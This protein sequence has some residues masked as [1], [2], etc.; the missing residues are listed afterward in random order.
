M[1][2]GTFNIIE[3]KVYERAEG[4]LTVN[5]VLAFL[6]NLNLHIA[7]LVHDNLRET[8]KAGH[9]DRRIQYGEVGELLE[10]DERWDRMVVHISVAG[11]RNPGERALQWDAQVYAM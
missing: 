7:I 4:R 6:R 2:G 9:A 8:P 10:Q 5:V 11:D 3:A 1:A